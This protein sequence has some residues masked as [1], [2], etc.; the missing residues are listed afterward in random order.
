MF[1]KIEQWLLVLELFQFS[2]PWAE[3]YYLK[4]LVHGLENWTDNHCLML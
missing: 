1:H 4:I 2:K 3:V